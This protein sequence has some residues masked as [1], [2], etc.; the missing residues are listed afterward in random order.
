[1]NDARSTNAHFLQ[2]L[3]DFMPGML[4]Y[5]NSA[6]VCTFA[7][8]AYLNW[9]GTTLPEMSGVL[10]QDFL[11]AA[12][13]HK[14]EP[15]IRA[16]LAGEIQEFERTHTLP[17]G[18]IRE[19]LVH[20]IPHRQGAEV[21]GF[22]ALILDTTEGMRLEQ[23]LVAAAEKH[24]LSMGHELHDNLGQQM[25]A[26]AY[27]AK[28]LEK[29]LSTAG[30]EDAATVA[31]SIAR[32]AQNA[33]VHCKQIAQGA[34]PFELEANGLGAA[35]LV[36]ASEISTRYETTCE[37]IGDN[38]DDFD[39]TD[40]ALHLY[41]IAQEATHNAIRHGRASQLTISL[42]AT[43]DMLCLSISDNGCGLADAN[44][45]PREST[46]MGIK[47][48]QFRA[49]QLG[50]SLKFLSTAKGGTQVLLDMPLQKRVA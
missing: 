10:I 9:F 36:F 40:R 39:D 17:N 46:G 49:R 13:F 43:Q 12:Q 30:N 28:A 38:A 11:G 4:G 50:A 1:M 19:T 6:M 8:R 31:A 48:M 20:Y 37:F 29:K 7:N 15:F 41:R 26:I 34:L 5:W 24:Q 32:Q 35:L 3:T 2:T 45:R 18:E 47:I 14:D 21:L 42:T 33:V 23:A 44:A 27:Q 22:F 25:A 16:A